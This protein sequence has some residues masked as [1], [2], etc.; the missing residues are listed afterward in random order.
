MLERR[1]CTQGSRPASF[2]MLLKRIV[3]WLRN[4]N[5]GGETKFYIRRESFWQIVMHAQIGAR[6]WW[7]VK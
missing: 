3:Q 5:A 2:V 6:K 1:R 7:L 4:A